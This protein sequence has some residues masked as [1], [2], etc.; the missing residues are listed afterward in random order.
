MKT[1]KVMKLPDR[2]MAGTIQARPRWTVRWRSR[3]DHAVVVD[4]EGVW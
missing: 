3:D 2:A 4:A 1:G